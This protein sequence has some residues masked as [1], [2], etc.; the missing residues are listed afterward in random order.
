M[1]TVDG[2][3]WQYPCDA[4]RISEV[5]S[6]DISGDTMD[7]GYFNDVD[8]TYISYAL[9]L[10][11]PLTDKDKGDEIYEI[12]TEPVDGHQFVF[13]YGASTIAITA[14]I[15]GQIKDVYR[16]LSNGITYWAGLQFTVSSNHPYKE[17]SESE[18]VTRGRAPLPDVAS[19]SIG[20][21]YA[22]TADGWALVPDADDTAY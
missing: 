2:I 15:N 16:R 19:P 11:I 21:T 6:S 10:A 1:F 13:P 3:T 17:L 18:V 7:G 9:K 4:E 5:K 12:L 22:Y 14:R 20:D 8:G